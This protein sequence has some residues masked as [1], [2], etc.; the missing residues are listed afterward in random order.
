MA[1]LHETL[2][3][4]AH[5]APRLELGTVQICA[6]V[7]TR[8]VTQGEVLAEV[9]EERLSDIY[10]R[11]VELVE[12]GSRLPRK[13][14]T[15]GVEL[16]RQQG[17]LTRVDGA[18]LVRAG[19]FSLTRLGVAIADT[20]LEDE[21]LTRQSLVLL[22]TALR[23][24][25]GELLSAAH[26]AR[27]AEEW[28]N[29]RQ[30]LR[31]N[32][33]TLVE[34][35]DRRRQGLDQQQAEVQAQVSEL[36]AE[37]WYGAA[38][39]CERVMEETTATLGELKDVLVG[40]TGDL[41]NL[42]AEIEALAGQAQ[43]DDAGNAAREAQLKVDGIGAWGRARHEAWSEYFGTVQ[44]FLRDHVRM[45]PDRAVSRRL[46]E[47]ITAW[48]DAPWA[49]DVASAAPYRYLRQPEPERR[50]VSVR[51]KAMV[52]ESEPATVDAKDRDADLVARVGAW[53]DAN[54]RGELSDALAE[55]LPEK[56]RFRFAGRIT[57]LLAKLGDVSGELERP[58]VVVDADL[59]VEQWQVRRRPGAR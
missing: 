14:A 42:L 25:L 48:P 13:K 28:E 4:V 9:D 26:A 6:L 31:V 43:A 17:L 15:H 38:E 57:R 8:L 53:L 10:V 11:V 35:I 7:A 29:I 34:G 20:W 27:T 44:R 12:G 37:S 22:T 41:L 32:V 54:P 36:L 19:A 40:E 58:W 18:G 47:A 3:R 56:D 45:D 5:S 59:E 16:L 30:K 51:R 39:T 23:S 24:N 55:L 46:Q 2:A 49:L 1:E 52:R 21:S 33:V 50:R